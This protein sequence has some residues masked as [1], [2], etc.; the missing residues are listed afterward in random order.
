MLFTSRDFLE[1]VGLAIMSS[2]I[3]HC[4]DSLQVSH[5]VL[6]FIG[7]AIQTMHVCVLLIEYP[8]KLEHTKFLIL[9]LRSERT[10]VT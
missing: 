8:W 10:S 5:I 4:I 2:P 6:Y 3:Y 1:Q 9:D 7:L